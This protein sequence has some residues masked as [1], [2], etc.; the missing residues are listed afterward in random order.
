MLK[1]A[2]QTD[3]GTSPELSVVVHLTD[4]KIERYTSNQD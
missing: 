3:N 4:W 1:T 2:Q